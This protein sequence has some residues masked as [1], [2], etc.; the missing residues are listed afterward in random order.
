MT[1]G[2]E[3]LNTSTDKDIVVLEGEVKVV[4]YPQEKH[5]FYLWDMK[6]LLISESME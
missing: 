2:V 6:Q 4:L 1:I 3:I 5:T